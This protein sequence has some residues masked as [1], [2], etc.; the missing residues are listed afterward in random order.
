MQENY[1]YWKEGSNHGS[2]E[3]GVI[4]E[5]EHTKLLLGGQQNFIS[6]MNSLFLKSCIK[7]HIWFMWLSVFWVLFYS[8]II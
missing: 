1:K 3:E 6:D 8:K 4:P 7:P 2:G 5:K